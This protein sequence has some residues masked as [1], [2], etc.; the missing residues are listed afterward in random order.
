MNQELSL[1]IEH[2]IFVIRGHKVMLDADLAEL[3]GVP[4][5]ALNQAVK[6][7]KKRFPHPFMLQLTQDELYSLRSQNVTASKRNVR[8]LPYAFTE[9]GALMAANV[10]NSPRA[11]AMSVKIIM[12]FVR[13]RQMTLS[14][15]ELAKKIHALEKGFQQH[16][17][18]FEVVFEAIRQLMTPPDPPRRRI[19]FHRDP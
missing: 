18:Q 1:Q 8:F 10:L 3:Y 9:Y 2:K 19:G 6:R 11:V 17:K 5:K 12:V 7:N 4:T 15:D 16:G 13:L 14:V